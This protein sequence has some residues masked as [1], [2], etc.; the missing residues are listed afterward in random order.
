MKIGRDRTAYRGFTLVELLVVIAII[1][2]LVALLLPAI[3]AAREAARRSE[4][5]NNL[6][7]I[8]LAVHNYH[9]TFGAFPPAT[10]TSGSHGASAFVRIL[11]FVEYG[12]AFDQLN[13]IGFGNQTNYWLGS[14]SANTALI[15]VI[16][17]ELRVDAY[18]C[19]S[20][21]FP[22]TRTINGTDQMMGSYV[23]IAGSNNHPSTDQNGADGGH[24]SGGGCFPGNGVIHMSD[25]LD[26][27]SN[28]MM[29][30]E[31][32]HWVYGQQNS[33]RIAFED[34]GPWMGGK[35]KRVPN[36]NGTW[37]STGTHATNV[38]DQDMRSYGFTTIRQ[39]PNPKGTANWQQRVRC[40]TPLTSAH[41]GGVLALLGDGKIRFI[42][43]DIEL[44]TL[45]NLA[46]RDDGNVLGEY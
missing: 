29:I 46:D 13:S 44:Q 30:G 32:S 34:S 39:A 28:T 14:P 37:S 40:N 42:G 23:L 22:R 4:C 26:G 43:D 2:I 27:T 25:I 7:Q 10:M 6:K 19:P 12:A 9:D 24:C 45:K 38:S 36:G 41:P 8:G 5:T 15:K 21:P 18:R 33:F 20:S 1:G 11:P 3:Q 31:Q 17:A 16:L 35:N